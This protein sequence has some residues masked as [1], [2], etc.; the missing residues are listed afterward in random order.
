VQAPVARER[1][2]ALAEA[3]TP[4][5][6]ATCAR[7]CAPSYSNRTR[8]RRGELSRKSNS[9]AWRSTK[10]GCGAVRPSEVT[11]EYDSIV[12]PC[13]TG[14]VVVVPSRAR[15]GMR[16]VSSTPSFPK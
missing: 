6:S 5:S 11:H 4:S 9:G 14:P 10:L 7:T 2:G 1:A 16:D 13:C 15:S 8:G 12:Q 3:V